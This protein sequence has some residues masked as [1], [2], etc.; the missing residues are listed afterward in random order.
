[1]KI[2]EH[3]AHFTKSRYEVIMK[4]DYLESGRILFLTNSLDDDRIIQK[5]VLFIT[6]YINYN[7]A[8]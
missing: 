1:M 3:K 6:H 4:V 2:T 5:D 8:K 7:G